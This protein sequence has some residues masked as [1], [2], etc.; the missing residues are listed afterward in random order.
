MASYTD[1]VKISKLKK[2]CALCVAAAAV[3][4]RKKQHHQAEMEAGK[5]IRKRR[6]LES[7]TGFSRGLFN[8]SWMSM[9]SRAAREFL[10]GSL[11]F[12]KSWWILWNQEQRSTTQT[13]G[14]VLVWA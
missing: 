11:G 12:S 9:M 7:E 4:I 8:R 3:I 10:E 5:K 2:A 13:T 14:T 6:P 1:E